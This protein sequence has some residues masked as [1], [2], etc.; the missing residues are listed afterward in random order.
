MRIKPALVKKIESLDGSFVKIFPK[1]E[2]GRVVSEKT[3]KE[4]LELMIYVVDKGTGKFAKI[5]DF[6]IAGKTGTAQKVKPG[7]FGYW[8]GHYVSSFIGVA[9]A[10]N[11]K[12]AVL[13]IIDEPKGVPWGERVAAPVFARVMEDTLRYLNIAPDDVTVGQGPMDSEESYGLLRSF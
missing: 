3:S 9:P 12:I 5:K 8:P 10:T 13:V 4:M 7:G 1:E 6:K 11:P 2:Q